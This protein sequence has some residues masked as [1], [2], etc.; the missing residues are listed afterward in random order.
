MKI[1]FDELAGQLQLIADKVFDQAVI[2]QKFSFLTGNKFEQHD[3][4]DFLCHKLPIEQLNSTMQDCSILLSA[5]V[6]KGNEKVVE[7][8]LCDL[9]KLLLTNDIKNNWQVVKI[10]TPSDPFVLIDIFATTSIQPQIVMLGQNETATLVETMNHDNGWLNH[11]NLDLSFNKDCV[12]HQKDETKI[13]AYEN[14]SNLFIKLDRLSYLWQPAKPASKLLLKQIVDL[15]DQQA[16]ID[17]NKL[18]LFFKHTADQIRDD[19]IVSQYQ[20]PNDMNKPTCIK[21][22]TLDDLL[23]NEVDHGNGTIVPYN[24]FPVEDLEPVLKYLGQQLS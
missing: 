4:T 13:G 21:T 3:A 19:Y 6:G 17:A 18:D 14:L 23:R 22:V 11:Y 1:D 15:N 16:K 20:F 8:E 10:T 5:L 24:Q 9:L 7:K 2:F 12:S